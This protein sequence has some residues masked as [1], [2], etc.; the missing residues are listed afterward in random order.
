VE[1]S[2]SHVEQALAAGLDVA[3]GDLATT[4]LWPGE[5]FDAVVMIEVVEHVPDPLRL[6]QVA[7]GRLV[8]GGATFLTTPNFG[9]VTRRLLGRRWSVLSWEHVSLATP[10]GLARA[11]EASGHERIRI[12]S[13][14][15]YVG[16][17]RKLLRRP[18][19]GETRSLSEEN[20]V[21]RD[22]IEGSAALRW[23]KGA[24]NAV[25]GALDLGEGLEAW[26]LRGPG[27]ARGGG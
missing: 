22:R 18:G 3:Y 19:A 21:L 24:A 5:R 17:Y 13:K 12:R 11:L 16:E 1:L 8:P 4:D 7:S 26:A 15:L 27:P 6:L 14:N 25:L 20:V 10:R 2:R 9:S 23:G